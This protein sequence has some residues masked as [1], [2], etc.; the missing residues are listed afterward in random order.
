LKQQY[1]Q[2]MKEISDIEKEKRSF[3]DEDG[4]G[5]EESGD[6]GDD[7][8]IVQQQQQQT[9]PSLDASNYTPVATST[10]NRHFYP[11]IQQQQQ[12]QHHV[13][14][15]PPQHLGNTTQQMVPRSSYSDIPPQYNNI[16]SQHTNGVV[17]GHQ[18]HYIQQQHQQNKFVQH[19]RPADQS[20]FVAQRSPAVLQY[21]QEQQPVRHREYIQQ[22]QPQ[23]HRDLNYHVQTPLLPSIESLL[24]KSTVFTDVSNEDPDTTQNS[25]DTTVDTIYRPFTSFLSTI[26]SNI[27]LTDNI[28]SLFWY[29][30]S[31][32][33]KLPMIYNLERLGTNYFTAQMSQQA[34]QTFHYIFAQRFRFVDVRMTVPKETFTLYLDIHGVKLDNPSNTQ[35]TLDKM[36]N[37]NTTSRSDSGILLSYQKN[38][39]QIVDGYIWFLFLSV[40]PY[41]GAGSPQ[42]Q[43]YPDQRI[44]KTKTSM[45]VSIKSYS[46]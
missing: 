35:A 32:A 18:Q 28:G 8:Y 33:Q 12:Q 17:P 19:G 34:R 7:D 24:D 3:G 11:I 23:Q 38:K 42:I 26:Q 25:L 46:A 22:Q 36:T 16:G 13:Y 1:D 31:L 37:A 10:T 21:I 27:M 9:S 5:G 43:F 15:S 41:E 4:V 2:L 39:Q 20:T 14:T 6:D 40:K 29:S 30:E 45:A 44:E